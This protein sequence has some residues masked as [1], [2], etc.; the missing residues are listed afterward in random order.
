METMMIGPWLENFTYPIILNEDEEAPMKNISPSIL[1]IF[2][3]KSI[4]DLDQFLFEFKVLYQTY[5]YK[6]DKQKLKLFPSTL[7]DSTMRWF[8]GFPSNSIH[9]WEQMETSF[10]D[11]PVIQNSPPR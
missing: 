4:E 6:T 2:W 3:G 8:M 1:P 7:K 11:I 10:L 9:S 5:D